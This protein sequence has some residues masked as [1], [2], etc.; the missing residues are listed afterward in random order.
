MDI[1]QQVEEISELIKKFKPKFDGDQTCG[2]TM[3]ELGALLTVYS[4]S[5]ENPCLT[6]SDAGEV[7]GLCRPAMSQVAAKL[8]S[9][10]MLKREMD[11]SDRRKVLVTV[12]KKAAEMIQKEENRRRENLTNVV[13]ELGEKDCSEFIR[14][15][16]RFIQITGGKDA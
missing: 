9:K 5:K 14:L 4:L 2:L 10:G 3:G 16:K 1:E 7:I 13:K 6:M 12:T 11:K 8:E 15:L